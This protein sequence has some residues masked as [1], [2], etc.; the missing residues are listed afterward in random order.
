MVGYIFLCS[1][2][3]NN[4]ELSKRGRQ[5]HVGPGGKKNVPS[6]IILVVYKHIF[7][8]VTL[9]VSIFAEIP[10]TQRLLETMDISP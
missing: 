9:Y 5:R 4:R 7:T 2:S 8:L 6:C 3:S 10:F 1:S